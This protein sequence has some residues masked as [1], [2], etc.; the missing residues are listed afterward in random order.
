MPIAGVVADANVILS[1]VLGKAAL[2]V[3]QEFGIPVHTTLFNRDEVL[4]YLPQLAGNWEI[5]IRMT[6]IHWRWLEL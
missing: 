2:K 3:F 4:E 5:A 1:A 6:R